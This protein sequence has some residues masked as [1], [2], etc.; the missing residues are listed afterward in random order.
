MKGLSGFCVF[1]TDSPPV[2][3]S[4]LQPDVHL[5]IRTSVVICL[6][7]SIVATGCFPVRRPPSESLPAKEVVREYLKGMFSS[8]P[9]REMYDLLTARARSAISY[10]A[11]VSTWNN[12]IPLLAGSRTATDTR[13]SVSFFDQYDFSDDHSVAYSLLTVR[14]PYSIGEREKYALVRLHCYR[15]GDAWRVEPFMHAQTGTV[16]LIPTRTRGPLWRI[17]DDMELIAKL[18]RDEISMYEKEK[19]PPPEKVASPRSPDEPPLVVPDVVSTEA[20]EASP[21]AELDRA[22]KVDAL[23]SIGKLCYRAGKI[24]AAEDTFRRVLALEPDNSVATDYLSRCEN[25]RLLLKEKGEAGKL[26]EELLQLESNERPR[27]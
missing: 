25:Y 19:H 5:A 26:I 17:S 16:I 8:S 13:V 12:E 18:V 24:D 11:F 20:P 6:L 14:H 9:Q 27:R 2:P 15:E 21:P 7:F 3:R 4:S 10:A 22:K 23:I 1:S